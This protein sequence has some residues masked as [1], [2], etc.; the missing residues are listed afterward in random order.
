MFHIL[1]AVE[2]NRSAVNGIFRGKK[3]TRKG[4]CNTTAQETQNIRELERIK[5]KK[6]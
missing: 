5:G 2:W 1:A 3:T 4:K 6:R